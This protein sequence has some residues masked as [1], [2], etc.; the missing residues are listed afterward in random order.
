MIDV[1][2]LVFLIN[3]LAAKNKIR[4]STIHMNLPDARKIPRAHVAKTGIGKVYSNEPI[5]IRLV[6][7]KI[8]IAV[9]KIKTILK[10]LFRNNT[11]KLIFF[12][13]TESNI[14]NIAPNPR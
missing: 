2:N 6:I 5:P 9:S 1:L 14:N 7:L 11:V 12:I 13:K 8:D 3:L 4:Y 10:L